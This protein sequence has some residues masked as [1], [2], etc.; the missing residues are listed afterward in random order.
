M[1]NYGPLALVCGVAAAWALGCSRTTT[2]HY[3]VQMIPDQVQATTQPATASLS[4]QT[5]SADAAYDDRRIVYRTSDVRL[6]YYHF[7]RWA[8]EPGAMVSTVLREVYRKSG[9]FQAV[10]GGF[11][12]ETD[13]VLSGRLVALEEV[14]I[15]R[16]EWVARISLEL[17]LR[18]NRTGKLLWNDLISTTEPLAEQSPAGLAQALSTAVTRVGSETAS[19][20]AAHARTQSPGN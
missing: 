6:D 19:V 9:Y 2:Q 11:A 10:V 14:D 12:R 4:V 16:D 3:Q 1:K 20:I 8:A 18:D 13:V 7:H 15:S 5:F 17:S